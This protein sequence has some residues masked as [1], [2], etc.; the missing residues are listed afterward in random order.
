M[1]YVYVLKSKKDNGLYV[2]YT[3]ELDR[4]LADHNKGL[5]SSTKNRRPF[6]LVYYEAYLSEGDA[7]KREKRLK[8][9][10]NAY[11][12]LTKRIDKS[13]QI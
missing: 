4:R 13:I 2:G 1:Y 9:F 12:E 8:Q 11:K 7:S 6:H 5:C 3:K 10:K